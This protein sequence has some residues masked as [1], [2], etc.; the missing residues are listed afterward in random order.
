LGAKSL[1]LA[2]KIRP[3]LFSLRFN[4]LLE[5]NKTERIERIKSSRR[6]RE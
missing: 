2:G 5:S 6:V 4:K 1:S 3:T